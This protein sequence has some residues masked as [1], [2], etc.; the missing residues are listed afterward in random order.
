[1]PTITLVK[2]VVSLNH[3]FHVLKKAKLLLGV[4]LLC[5]SMDAYSQSYSLKPN[6]WESL[7]VPANPNGQT[8]RQLFGDNMGDLEFGEQ[9]VVFTYDSSAGQYNKPADIDTVL[10][11]GQ[12]FWIVQIGDSVVDLDFPTNLPTVERQ[13]ST[14]CGGS[15]GCFIVPLPD[16]LSNV[17]QYQLLG[18]PFSTP[19]N[20]EN[21][22][23][24]TNSGASACSSGCTLD[25]ASSASFS[26]NFLWVYNS[27]NESYDQP[28]MGSSLAPWQG[29][30]VTRKPAAFNTQPQLEFPFNS[31][32]EPQAVA[33]NIDDV[34]DS[35]VITRKILLSAD[36]IM[37]LMY[38]GR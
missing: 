23:F 18:A 15:Y 16:S 20:I 34:P 13:Y 14:S 10:A 17:T 29:F 21:L 8:V 28:G 11:A 35:S 27:T 22:R 7:V 3:V 32:E 12:A 30:W 5:A 2:N 33:L 6:S 4:A 9:W 31:A 24:T 26:D 25:A 37:C 36:L 38:L 1:M 19:L